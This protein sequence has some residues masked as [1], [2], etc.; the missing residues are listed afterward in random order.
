ME[1]W[2]LPVQFWL[3][4]FGLNGSDKVRCFRPGP[5]QSVMEMQVRSRA[6]SH[7][8]PQRP[9]VVSWCFPCLCQHQTQRGHQSSQGSW[10]GLKQSSDLQRTW[11]CTGLATEE[12]EGSAHWA[13]PWG[14]ITQWCFL[15]AFS[16]MESERWAP[17]EF[18]YRNNCVILLFWLI[19]T[20]DL[21]V[22]T[23][24]GAWQYM[25]PQKIS[26]LND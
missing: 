22:S 10:A 24:L 6:E 19:L 21:S 8:F 15:W 11:Q 18:N 12:E 3:F 23:I 5:L 14:Q 13:M 4:W 7:F 1:P 16:L 26:L 20:S 25:Y 9:W 2:F 17:S